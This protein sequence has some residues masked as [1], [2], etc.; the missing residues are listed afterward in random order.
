MVGEGWGCKAGLGPVIAKRLVTGVLEYA[1][2][3]DRMPVLLQPCGAVPKGTAPFYL[4]TADARF[5]ERLYLDWK[6]TYTTAAQLSSTLNL[7]D[8]QSPS[9]FQTRTT[10]RSGLVAGASCSRSSRSSRLGSPTR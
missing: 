8:F 3:A 2:W 1:A 7:C 5:P 10:F 6:A 9:T 4:L